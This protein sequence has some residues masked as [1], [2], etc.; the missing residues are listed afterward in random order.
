MGSRRLAMLLRIGGTVLLAILLYVLARRLDWALLGHAL[1]HASPWP[2]IVATLLFFTTLLGKAIVWRILLAPANVVPLG[3]LYRYTVLAFAGSVLAP[4]RAG[5]LLRVLALKT[6]DGVP[7]TD[8]F[9]AAVT[10][11]LL[12]AVSLLALAAPL[13]L[14]LP[15]LPAWVDDSLAACAVI[16]AGVLV[17][18]YIA[19]GRVNRIGA[20]EP[21]SWLARTIAGMAAVRDPR[22]LAASLGVLAL[23][24]AADLL[25]I[26]TVLRAVHVALPASGALFILF[27]LNLAIAVP[28]TPANVGTLQLGALAATQLLGLPD[29]PALAFALLYHAIQI[30]PLLVVAF[31]LEFRLMI[32]ARVRGRLA[33]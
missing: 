11:K 23:V 5:E 19:V 3:H 4:A 7:A 21:R 12:H 30:I 6:R 22:R 25:T 24:W 18:I 14:L 20:R 29:E 17:A 8:A 2:I 33:A 16:A 10:D 32:P 27:A 31:V 26:I 9:G 15:A 13:P 1:R 28:V